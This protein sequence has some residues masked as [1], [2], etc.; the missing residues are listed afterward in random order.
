MIIVTTEMLI[1]QHIHSSQTE[2][3]NLDEELA[4]E[5]QRFEDESALQE[6][7]DSKT[8]EEHIKDIFSVVSTVS[9]A[10]CRSEQSLKVIRR[11][12]PSQRTLAIWKR[13]ARKTPLFVK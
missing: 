9:Q 8:K 12:A 6:E 3:M 11:G 2:Q 5:M 7:L 10:V 1:L 13:E 4:R